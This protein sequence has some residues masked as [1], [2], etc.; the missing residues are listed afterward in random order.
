MLKSYFSFSSVDL[1]EHVRAEDFENLKN[2]AHLNGQLFLMLPGF[3]TV[4]NLTFLSKLKSLSYCK[5]FSYNLRLFDEKFTHDTTCTCC[6]NHWFSQRSI[7]K[8]IY[9]VF[10]HLYSVNYA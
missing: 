3:K 8:Y 7:S 2:L 10:L 4:R 1:Q 6:Y 5:Y 9:C